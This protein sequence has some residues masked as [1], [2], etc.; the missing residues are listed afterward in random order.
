VRIGVGKPP[1]KERGGDHVLGRI[2]TAERELLDISV[3]RAADAVEIILK[4]GADTA[5]QQTNAE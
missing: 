1:S 5:M 3:Q 4:H 2:P